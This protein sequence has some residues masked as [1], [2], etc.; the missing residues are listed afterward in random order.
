MD[1]MT[2]PD[3]QLPM[4]TWGQANM[5]HVEKYCATGLARNPNV[6]LKCDFPPGIG[7][8]KFVPKAGMRADGKAAFA[9]KPSANQP[10]V[11][12]TTAYRVGYGNQVAQAAQAMAFSIYESLQGARY[13]TLTQESKVNWQINKLAVAVM[14]AEIKM[15]KTKEPMNTIGKGKKTNKRIRIHAYSRA[16]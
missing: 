2:Y 1:I 14:N 7:M 15:Q 9:A 8:T 6:V 12:M 5:V 11:T 13:A 3:G 4:N 10:R 16:P